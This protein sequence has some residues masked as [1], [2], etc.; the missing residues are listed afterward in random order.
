M[1]FN[2]N[3]FLIFFALFLICYW[4]VRRSMRAR[5]ALILLAS[6]VFYCSWDYRFGA[7][8][9]FTSLADFTFARLLDRRTS[10][11]SRKAFLTASL[12]LNLGVLGF[13]K[14]FNFF[15]DG[16]RTLLQEHFGRHLSWPA[17]G[18][19]LPIGVSFY[20]FQSMSYVI[21]VYRRKIP[22]SRNIIEFLAFVS[23]FP[24]LVAGPIERAGH[25]L[26]QF[27]RPLSISIENVEN[28]VWLV[29]WGLF[30]KVV[31]ADNLAPLSDLILNHAEPSLPL[32][33]LGTT[34]FALQ[35]YCDFAGYSN[36]ARGLARLLGFEL[37]INFNLPYLAVSLQKFW[38]RWHIS[39]STWI[40]DYLYIPLGGNRRGES[41]TCLNLVVAMGLA[42]LW[43]GAAANFVL[44]GLWHGFGLVVNRTWIRLR[45]PQLSL[46][47]WLAWSL[48][49]SFVWAGW[50]LFRARSL[51]QIVGLFLSL[52]H[53]TL[54]SW[55]PT[56]LASLLVLA[57]P[58]ILTHILQWR[59]G[60]PDTFGLFERPVR[61][62]VQ[63]LLVLLISTWWRI[64]ESPFIY[65]QF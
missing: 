61:L 32:L 12:S 22:A 33:L 23:F 54:P 42:G 3:N 36:V 41:R 47:T 21:D 27:S 49:I 26:N 55:W 10:S 65:F 59:R 44:W 8:L 15:S 62:A 51:D 53:M 17:L 56:Y 43:H 25:M 28:G 48:T 7:L 39:L 6:Y 64:E 11:G 58:V 38:Q 37:M 46:P 35:I 20:T 63:G 2:S 50:A 14:Y 57:G 31:L 34:A 18:I 9:L 16:L 29:I 19:L 4:V 45:P 40:R 24:Q 5:N 1:L 60:L 30:E 52:R 13:F